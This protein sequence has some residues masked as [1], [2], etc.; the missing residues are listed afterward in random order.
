MHRQFVAFNGINDFYQNGVEFID[1]NSEF[2]RDKIT[3]RKTK[4][5]ISLRNFLCYIGMLK[6][7][8]IASI[9]FISEPDKTLLNSLTKIGWKIKVL[10]K[11]PFL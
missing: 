9:L 7:G 4:F 11:N 6:S 2:I 5:I 8:L 10:P 3:I 1:M